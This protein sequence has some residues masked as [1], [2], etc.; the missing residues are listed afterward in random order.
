MLYISLEN[1]YNPIY[2]TFTLYYI[3][4]Q[5]V[6][7]RS[8][9]TFSDNTFWQNEFFLV[10]KNINN[11]QAKVIVVGDGDL[12]DVDVEEYEIGEVIED[13]E[14]AN[15]DHEEIVAVQIRSENDENEYIVN[16][17]TGEPEAK[18]VELDGN[19]FTCLLCPSDGENKPF[20]CDSKDLGFLTLHLKVDHDV[21]LA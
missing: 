10:K 20:T 12:N 17:Q 1:I 7:F 8:T 11:F 14:V 21:S 15:A 5:M 18:H 4:L 19:K 6:V 16:Q 9:E 3:L 13:F 2:T